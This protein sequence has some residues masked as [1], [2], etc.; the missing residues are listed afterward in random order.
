MMHTALFSLIE[1]AQKY[2]TMA[3]RAEESLD[4]RHLEGSLDDELTQF[5]REIACR[6]REQAEVAKRLLAQR[7]AE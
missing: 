7:V 1:D 3:Q 5:L 4:L 6:S 2:G